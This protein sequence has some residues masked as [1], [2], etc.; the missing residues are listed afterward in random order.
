MLGRYERR[1][2]QHDPSLDAP[3]RY[4]RACSYD[5]FI[6]LPIE[7]LEV[8][9]SGSVAASVSEAEAA[10]RELN[11]GSHPALAPLAR[12]LLRTES[13][14]SSKVEGMQV[15]ARALARAEVSSDTGQQ[16]APTALE[17][18]GN[19]DAMQL[20]VE[21]TTAE[22]SVGVEQITEIHRALLARA[23]NSHIAGRIR[24]E[25]NW[26]GGNNYNPCG[27]DFVPPPPEE[28]EWLLG[29]LSRFSSADRLPPLV[30]AAIAHAQ[31]ETVHPFEDG[32]G[33]TGRALVQVIL[34]WRGLA[35][36]YVPPISVVLAANK[37]RYIHGLTAYREGQIEA[38][39]E[40]FSVAAARAAHL[41]LRY[42]SE[43]SSLQ[44]SWRLMLRQSSRIRADAAAWR[45]IDVLPAQSIVTLPTAVARVERT[46]PA[47]NQAIEQLV[48]A[49]VLVPV[50]TGK[51]NRAWEAVG[52]LDLLVRL[53]SGENPE[54]GPDRAPIS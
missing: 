44:E 21:N 7:E 18:L 14:A 19:I 22:Q 47:V 46:K 35:P 32:N 26:I 15:D 37:E 36:T 49:G 45:L 5:A 16:A 29:D 43:V 42:L 31:F 9:I 50:S 41:A 33:R 24:T 23:P 51:R 20:A 13:I 3:H 25:Q 4:R 8:S 17:V 6:P 30:Q 48:G 40:V 10:I 54:G 28:V 39:L 52:L 1:T 2:W 27:A 12:L 38:W 34:R 11:A 53:E